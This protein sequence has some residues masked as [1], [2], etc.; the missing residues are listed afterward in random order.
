MKEMKG[1]MDTKLYVIYSLSKDCLSSKNSNSPLYNN[2]AHELPK[3]SSNSLNSIFLGFALRI[4]TAH[5]L[6]R[7]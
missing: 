2:S 4:L 7:H 6:W 1:L 3:E 5:N